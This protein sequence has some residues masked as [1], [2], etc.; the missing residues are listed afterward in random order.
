MLF[1]I[2]LSQVSSARILSVLAL[3]AGGLGEARAQSIIVPEPSGTTYNLGTLLQGKTV[4]TTPVTLSQSFYDNFSNLNLSTLGTVGK[5]WEGF[6]GYTTPTTPDAHYIPSNS[7]QQFY[8]WPG[9]A[10]SKTSAPLNLNPFSYSNGALNITATKA[11]AAQ[12]AAMGGQP[13]Y[14]GLLTGIN[15]FSQ[16]Y[17]YFE[18]SAK[19][20][21]GAGMWP[22]FWLMPSNKTWPPEIDVMEMFKGATPNIVT[23]TTHWKD[24]TNPYA[25]TYCTY[26]ISD[27]A[28]NFHKYGVLWNAKQITYYLDRVPVCVMATPA[29]LQTTVPMFPL[30]NLA[31]EKGYSPTLTSGT[32]SV[33]YF[34][35]YAYPKN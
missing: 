20:P 16:L 31:V 1:K 25:Q 4:T 33:Q 30:I 29:Q 11:T 7:E 34:A 14:S 35:A 21:T 8:I 15:L 18:I 26:N 10:A 23:S 5:H 3:L 9:Y 13:F 22:A 27:A 12:A 28:T 17:G 32:Y 2:S 24:P 19:M 6:Y